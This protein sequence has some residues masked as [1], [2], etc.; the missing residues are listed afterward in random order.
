M[1]PQNVRVRRRNGTV[2]PC[3]LAPAEPDGDYEM[4][5]IATKL[6][7]GDQLLI[8]FL[9]A[10]TG[11]IGPCDHGLEDGVAVIESEET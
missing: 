4:W 1:R 10:H 8:G 6:C 2:I 11:L 3:E 7:H 5:E 9:P